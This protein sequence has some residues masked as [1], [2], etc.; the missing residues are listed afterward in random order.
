MGGEGGREKDSGFAFIAKST[1]LL[2]YLCFNDHYEAM[3]GGGGGKLL[4]AARICVYICNMSI[5]P[6]LGVCV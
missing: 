2:A 6:P 5:F 1:H 4:K 3:P